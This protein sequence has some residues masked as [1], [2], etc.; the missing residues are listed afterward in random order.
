[1]DFN[2]SEEQT[3]F[4]DLFRDFSE[5]EA[6]RLAE[7][8]DK[9]EAPPV[10]VLRKAAAQGFLGAL[11]PEALG[12]AAMDTQTYCLLLEELAK[13]CA[14]TAVTVAAHT[15]LAGLPILT[16]GSEAQ[17]QAFLPRLAGGAL[18][19]GALTE[20]E[21]DSDTSRLQTRAA[22]AAGGWHF[23]GVK[24]WVSN[25]GLAEVFVVYAATDPAKGPAGISAFILEK[26]A[27]WL[28]LGH[29][30]P[31]LGLRGLDVRTLYLEGG[32]LPEAGL[33]GPLN[34]GWALAQRAQDHFKLALAAV[35][36]G[37]AESALQ[38]GVSFAVERKQFGTAIAQKGA[39]QAYLADA[40]V[41]IE[42]VRGLVQ[43]AAWLADQGQAYS[44]AAGMAKYL[45]ARVAKETA[46]RMLQVHGGYGFSDE[47]A[48]SRVYRDS[49]A[50]KIMGGTD[51]FQ[52]FLLAQDLLAG[53]GVAIQP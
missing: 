25:G 41:E 38:L 46:N 6:G 21:A 16:A 42:A 47:Y 51:E 48:I 40:S 1:M 27:P 19:A 36:L 39:I 50:L 45:A 34:G 2:L 17:Q 43:R 10:E 32:P 23:D 11:F 24:S 35:G 29:R 26:G 52:R 37:I 5:K 4:R 20:P 15:S 49:R 3:M 7:H 31:T 12:G 22:L 44:Q 33:L 13:Q 8:T 9:A 14:S 28:G 53:A 30:E 18:G